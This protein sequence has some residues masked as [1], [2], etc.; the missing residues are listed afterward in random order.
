MTTILQKLERG[1]T[2]RVIDADMTIST[3]E[4]AD[5]LNVSRP[6]IVKLVHAGELQHT[7]V[8]THHRLYPENVLMYK[9]CMKTKRNAALQILADEAQSLDMGY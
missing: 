5:L 3:Q 1:H 8:G 2:V 7:M 9:E 4:A 6:H